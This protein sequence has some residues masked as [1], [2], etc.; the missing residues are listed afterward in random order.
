[1]RDK[2]TQIL[3]GTFVSTFL[4]SVLV[5]RAIRG[6]SEAAG[7][8][9]A[10]SIT[11]GIVLSVFSLVLLVYFI[12]H[13]SASIQASHIV[14]VI[15]EDLEQAIPRL[16][17]SQSGTPAP[18]SVDDC[19]RQS[20]GTTLRS[21]KTGYLQSLDLDQLLDI[22]SDLDTVIELLPAPGDHL[23]Q[24]DP[25]ARLWGAS[26]PDE[27]TTARI[28]N[29]FL[30][31]GE[32]TP[33]QDI[34]YQF[35]QLTDVVIRALSPGINDPFTAVNGI[36]KIAGGVAVLSKR[37][38]VSERRSDKDGTLRLLVSP[39]DLS[40]VL[41]ETVS[42]IAVYASADHFVMASLRRV[43]DVAERNHQGAKEQQVILE[44]REQLD[45]LQHRASA[46]HV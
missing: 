21:Q 22:A 30:I 35:Q 9:P 26:N 14:N 20:S 17:P 4:Y 1:M 8:V 36:D 18:D 6:T 10:I 11:V 39:P 3:L 23:V 2:I 31:G 28:R 25:I 46:P 27:E 42:H 38:R 7:F 40:C 19:F 5:V 34:R 44:L 32:R 13:V 12:H 41:R 15:A 33:L 43:L 16:Y 29:A 45:R 37:P 24:D